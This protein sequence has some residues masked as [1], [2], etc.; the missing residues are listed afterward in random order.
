[1]AKKRTIRLSEAV[2]TVAAAGIGFCIAELF[3]GNMAAA[4]TVAAYSAFMCLWM[5]AS[6]LIGERLGWR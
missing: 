5:P 6:A 1:M 3:I 2:S 4:A